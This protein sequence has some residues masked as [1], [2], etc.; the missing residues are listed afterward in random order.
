[1]GK[2]LAA[3]SE[4]AYISEPLNIHHRPGVLQVP[5]KFWYTY[6]CEENH[7]LFLPGLQDT[8]R[9]QYHLWR[10]LNSLRSVKDVG[11]MCR[12]L[13]WFTLGR[14]RRARPLLKD[15]FAV[16]S[17]PWFAQTLG[18][19]VVNVVRHPLAFVSS[20][21]R[22][23]WDFD[24]RDLLAQPLLMRDYLEPFRGE[25]QALMDSP[26][27]VIAQGSLLWRMVY[28]V[29]DDFR[30][31]HP[32]FMV[33][34]H[35]DLSRQPEAG[36][37]DLYASLGLAFTPKVQHALENSSQSSNPA[38]LSARK[39]H[40]IN[41]DSRANLSNWQKRLTEDEITRIRDLTAAVAAKFYPEET[42]E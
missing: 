17:A 24:F 34:R 33:V 39:V 16:F 41:L 2:I 8:I 15:P 42:G 9:F 27:D 10:E 29:V 3:S 11:R 21:K 5:T 25:M 19:R 28:T 26:N 40:N 14:F 1:M 31:S 4:V 37:R 38:E 23:G 35:E 30:D 12:D 13:S 36:F 22:L 20:L 7:T 18:C 6:I 32:E